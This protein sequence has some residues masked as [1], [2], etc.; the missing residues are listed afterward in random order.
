MCSSDL[1]G[2][3]PPNWTLG[4]FSIGGGYGSHNLEDQA[5]GETVTLNQAEL[6][7]AW[8]LQAIPNALWLRVEPAL[9]LAPGTSNVYGA[10]I[11][12]LTR[13]IGPDLRLHLAGEGWSQKVGPETA[14]GSTVAIRAY[15]PFRTVGGT[16]LIPSLEARGRLLSMDTAPAGAVIDP[17]VWNAYAQAH[18]FGLSPEVL[19]WAMPFQDLIAY[20]SIGAV[21]NADV[22]SI[23]QLQASLVGRAVLHPWRVPPVQLELK[24]RPSYRFAS[25]YRDVAYLQHSFGAGVGTD[26]RLGDAM[27]VWIGVSD[28]A[29]LSAVSATQNVVRL[30]ARFDLNGGRAL[31]DRLP[32]EQ[33]FFDLLGSD[34]WGAL[35]EDGP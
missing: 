22:V 9:R 30:E 12:A 5:T 33:D 32:V 34:R 31:R 14:L 19:Y 23:D 3:A 35:N 26:V 4:T 24:Y 6:S 27:A 18:P 10:Q 15:R 1:A 11:D 8:R 13:F 20:A 7:A 2:N 25:A 21:T 28:L 29:Y 16:Y 17:D